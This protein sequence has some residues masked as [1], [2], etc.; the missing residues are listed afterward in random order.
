VGFALT[1]R[2]I[3]VLFTEDEASQKFNNLPQ[4]LFLGLDLSML[5]TPVPLTEICLGRPFQLCFFFVN[6]KLAYLTL[7]CFSDPGIFDGCPNPE[8][9]WYFKAKDGK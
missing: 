6:N 8:I 2:N 7:G 3:K 9:R 5:C 4:P 1:A